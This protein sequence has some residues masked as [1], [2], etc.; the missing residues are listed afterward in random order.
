MPWN[1]V[2]QKSKR[3]RSLTITSSCEASDIITGCSFF[4]ARMAMAVMG[5]CLW[6][7]SPQR[8]VQAQEGAKPTCG[9]VSPSPVLLGVPVLPHISGQLHR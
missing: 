8:S 2:T 6:S 1:N 7:W 4:L 5:C 9:G 3:G